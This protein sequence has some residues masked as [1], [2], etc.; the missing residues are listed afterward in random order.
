MDKNKLIKV[1]HSV[2]NKIDSAKEGKDSEE[3]LSQ[4]LINPNNST[5]IFSV[6]NN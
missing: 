6:D 2:L 5:E 4:M 1:P 3:K